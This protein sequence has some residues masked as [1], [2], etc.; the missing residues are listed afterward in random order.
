LMRVENAD[1]SC[2]VVIHQSLRRPSPSKLC[3]NFT[4]FA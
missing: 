4:P 3:L 1:M 2:M